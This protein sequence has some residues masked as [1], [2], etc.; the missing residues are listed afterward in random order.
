MQDIGARRD[1]GRM[2]CIDVLTRVDGE[3]EMVESGRVEQEL[4]FLERLPQSDRSGTGP[5]ETQIVNLLAPFA[6]VEAGSS[7]PS[8]PKTLR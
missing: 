3:R 5:R 7:S 6:W 8:G 1:R 2:G 4:L